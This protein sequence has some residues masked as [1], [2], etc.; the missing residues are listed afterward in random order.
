LRNAYNLK[1]LKEND[2][3]KTSL[4]TRYG[5]F[6][7]NAMPFVLMNALEFFNTWWMTYLKDSYMTSWFL[8][9]W[10]LDIFQQHIETCMSY[11]NKLQEKRLY[12]KLEKYF[13]SIKNR[14]LGL[15]L[16]SNNGLSMDFYKK[17]LSL[18]R[19]IFGSQHLMF[20]GI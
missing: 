18:I 14:A 7:Y 2:K 11:I 12:A 19:L 1:C 20:I 15:N 3:W 5:H 6:K 16:I 10:H 13:S 4:H 8:L 9:G 17:K